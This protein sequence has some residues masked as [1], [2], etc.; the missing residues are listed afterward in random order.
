MD[1][2]LAYLHGWLGRTEAH[3]DVLSPRLA[4]AF[5]ATLD[6]EPRRYETGDAAPLGIHWCLGNPAVRAS[7]L[8]RD[9]H[10]KRGDFM[11][12]VS[13]PRRMWA[14]GEL[15]FLAPLVVGMSVTR[16]STIA[17]LDAKQGRSGP[18][19]FL[20]LD[21]VYLQ[22]GRT[23][24]TERQTL[25]YREDPSFD[26]GKS[27]ADAHAVAAPEG[28]VVQRVTPNSVMLF[29]Y[30]ALTFNGHRIH[31]DSDYARDVEGYPD[32]VVHG[33][34]IATLLLRAAARRAPSRR[35]E[36]FSFRG[37]SPA[38]VGRPLSL[39]LEPQGAEV[40]A[41]ALSEER[42]TMTARARFAT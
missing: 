31:Y 4:E 40:N 12:P 35:M 5:D 18:L 9:G 21:H 39:S 28:A 19:V 30:S 8:G 42:I 17:S 26:S 27:E 1:A 34:L 38:F 41:T 11:P 16:Q 2:E 29:R 20:G 37:R 36:S 14:A 13:L 3:T 24:V 22:E 33:P 32:L 7:E 23:C 15:T 6:E 25:V 10:P